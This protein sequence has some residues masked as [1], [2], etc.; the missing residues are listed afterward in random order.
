MKTIGGYFGLE[1][2]KPG[3]FPHSNGLL[4]NSARNALEAILR[5]LPPGTEVL[6][7]RFT[8]EVVFEPF[9]RTGIGFS[10]YDVDD[11]L[12]LSE[13]PDLKESQYLLYTNYFGIKSQYVK[14]LS[15]IYNTKLIIDNAQAFFDV[16]EN[17]SYAVYSPRKF[18]GVADGGIATSSFPLEFDL[19]SD[20]SYGRFSHLLKR[21]DIGAEAGYADFSANDASLVGLPTRRMPKLTKAILESIDWNSVKSKRREN[22]AMLHNALGRYNQLEIPPSETYVCPMV[23][24]YWT[25][26]ATLRQR[27]ISN[28]V[29]VATYWP[30]V[31]RDNPKQ[32]PAHKL[33][34]SILPLPIDQRYGE[35]EMNHIIK[36]I[37]N[38]L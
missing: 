32:T 14:E 11:N 22:F 30:N 5:G 24:P 25:D 18:V 20:T 38:N 10:L 1:L 37:K 9:V 34:A 12:E 27:L 23:Y 15:A 21:L 4:V 31:L 16:P 33:S 26:D 17:G 8:C 13:L 7:P 35:E 2:P 19:E 36:L 6:L 28:K 29:F 3:A